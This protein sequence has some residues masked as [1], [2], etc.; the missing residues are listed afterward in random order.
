MIVKKGETVRVPVT[1]ETFGNVEKVLSLSIMPHWTDSEV[2]D[3]SELALFLD[4]ES[5][6]LSEDNMAQGKARI[7]DYGLVITDAGFLTITA[8]PAATGGTY[9]Y[10]VEANYAGEPGVGG[11][12]AGQLV[13]VTVMD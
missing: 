4:K 8:S 6:A 1:I 13:T 10:I 7:T 9:E 3:A 2:P 12:G 11:M 5:V